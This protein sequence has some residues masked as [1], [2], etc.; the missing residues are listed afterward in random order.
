[1]NIKYLNF[2]FEL[3]LILKLTREIFR[4][5]SK[6]ARLKLKG[7]DG[8]LYLR[9]SMWFNPKVRVESYQFLTI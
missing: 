4:L 5:G 7:I 8:S 2:L 1:M 9:W 3:N 6:T